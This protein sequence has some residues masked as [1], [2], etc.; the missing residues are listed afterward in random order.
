MSVQTEVAFLGHVVGRAGLACDPEKLSAVQTWHTP[1]SVKQVRQ[2]VG[3]V[4]GANGGADSQRDCF[5]M[6]CGDAGCVR[7]VEI[8]PASGP[9]LGFSS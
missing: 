5:R 2:F 4:V 7:R 6:D 9:N 1:D 3:F 8:L